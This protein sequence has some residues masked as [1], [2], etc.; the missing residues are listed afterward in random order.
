MASGSAGGGIRLRPLGIGDLLRETLRLYRRHA[1]AFL[2]VVGVVVVPTLL[3]EHAIRQAAGPLPP[4][5]L[6]ALPSAPPS[7]PNELPSPLVLVGIPLITLAISCVTNTLL[8]GAATLL[9]ANAILGAPLSVADG[10]RQSVRRL[11]ALLWAAIESTVKIVLFAI[12]IVGLYHAVRRLLGWWLI[13]PAIMLEG[14]AGSQSLRRSAALVD[15]HRPRVLGYWLLLTVLEW[16]LVSGSTYVLRYGV[17]LIRE[18][19]SASFLAPPIID[20]TEVLIGAVAATVFGAIWYIGKT[21]VYHQLRVR[22]ET[23]DQ[24]R[25]A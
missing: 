20:L 5:N 4:P 13:V 16:V 18:G 17:R 1:L 23:F 7:A 8:D 12:T 11:G 15:G 6:D 21:L 22:K 14:Q 9:A 10:Y 19:G 25:V 3:L 24:D 2:V